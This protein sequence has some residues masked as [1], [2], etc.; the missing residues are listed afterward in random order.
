MMG[1]HSATLL[2]MLFPESLAD[3]MH[4]FDTR[5]TILTLA[6]VAT[7]CRTD[8]DLRNRS[9]YWVQACLR[10]SKLGGLAESWNFF[11]VA[12]ILYLSG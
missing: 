10:Y 12:G 4:S 8:L 7:S 9:L 3:R 2:H 5:Q 1:T 6:I 11:L